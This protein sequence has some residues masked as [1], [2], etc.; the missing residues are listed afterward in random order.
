MLKLFIF[1]TMPIFL[2]ACFA[3]SKNSLTNTNTDSKFLP[4]VVSEMTDDI[5]V[6]SIVAL[7][8]KTQLL[9]DSITPL[10]STATDVELL[11]AQNNWKQ[12]SSQWNRVALYALGKEVSQIGPLNNDIV[13][14]KKSRIDPSIENNGL[15]KYET[16]RK[17]LVDNI[18]STDDLTQPSYFSQ[19]KLTN[20]GLLPLE[21][22]L[23]ED[24]GNDRDTSVSSIVTSYNNNARKCQY[25][26]GLATEMLE[27]TQYVAD[28]WTQNYR[29]TGKSFQSIFKQEAT[30]DNDNEPVVELLNS[31]QSYLNYYKD[32]KILGTKVPYV[33][34]GARL[35]ENFYADALATIDELELVL[36]GKP[37]AQNSIFNKMRSSNASHDVEL[38][39]E[40]ISGAKQAIADKNLS[41]MDFYFARLDGNVKR[42][43][44]QGL[45]LSLGLNFAD[46]D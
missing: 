23:F 20:V 43:V 17:A 25:L 40:N 31:F 41:N 44:A 1:A 42:E 37:D 33:L 6:P 29:S 46:G 13:N 16:V 18:A 36:T 4:Q 39:K 7:N 5:I 38:I 22:L 28:Q 35:S 21:I 45:G 15:D 12:V 11:A 26:S 27:S 10:C 3:E 30:F 19:L 9:K 34:V 8:D 24:L 2:T 14:S 32:K